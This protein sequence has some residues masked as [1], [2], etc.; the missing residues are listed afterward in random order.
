[1]DRSGVRCR[2]GAGLGS[3]AEVAGGADEADAHE[4][5]GH[6]DPSPGNTSL[7]GATSDRHDI[8]PETAGLYRRVLKITLTLRLEPVNQKVYRYGTLVNN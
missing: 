4:G 1:M 6:E 8:P 7:A 5:H 2:R 3:R